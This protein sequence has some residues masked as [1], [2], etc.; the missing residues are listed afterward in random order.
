MKKKTHWFSL[1]HTTIIYTSQQWFWALRIESLERIDGWMVREKIIKF[2]ISRYN[3]FLWQ[4]FI[5]Y[6]LRLFFYGL[7]VRVTRFSSITL[8]R[9]L[10]QS[11][12]ADL[13][14]RSDG[15]NR[16]KIKFSSSKALQVSELF[17][18]ECGSVLCFEIFALKRFLFFNERVVGM[19]K[20]MTKIGQ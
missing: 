7:W 18:R 5:D 1:H 13:K 6:A 3:S 17:F 15:E 10:A 14:W 16:V 2:K 4:F 12:S 11:I 9:S 20:S 8:S 19:G